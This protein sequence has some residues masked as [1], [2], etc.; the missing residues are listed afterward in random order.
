MGQSYSVFLLFNAIIDL[1]TATASA[2]GTVRV[3]QDHHGSMIFLFL[4]PCSF[5][6]QR[7]C[8]QCHALHVNL[9][10]QSTF[11][12]LLSFA[13][14]LYVVG[15]VVR[16]RPLKR[17]I[18][19]I[20]YFEQKSVS[21]AVLSRLHLTGYTASI[22]PI[23]GT[24]RATLLNT[25]IVMLSPTELTSKRHHIFI[26]RALTFQ[27]LLPLGVSVASTIWLWSIIQNQSNEFAERFL[28]IACSFFSLASPV[29]NLVMLPPYRA[30]ILCSK[31]TIRLRQTTF[32]SVQPG[33]ERNWQGRDAQLW[34]SSYRILLVHLT[35]SLADSAS[36]WTAINE[37][38][39]GEV[40]TLAPHQSTNNSLSTTMSSALCFA[41]LVAIAFGAPVLTDRQQKIRLIW[42]DDVNVTRAETILAEEAQKLGMTMDDY[43]NSCAADAESFDFT[44]QEEADIKQEMEA[45][46]KKVDNINVKT[47]DELFNILKQHAPKT[48]DAL[49]KRKAIFEKYFAK[50]DATAQQFVRNFGNALLES[51]NG[52]S[53]AEKESKNP[54]DLIEMLG[55]NIKKVKTEYDALPQS[56]KDSLERVFCIRS[57]LRIVD[58]YGLLKIV[59]AV[60]EAFTTM[61]VIIFFLV[62]L[63]AG[64]S[65]AADASHQPVPP[66]GNPSQQPIPPSGGPSQQPVPPPGASNQ[67]VPPP[68][69]TQQSK[70]KKVVSS[71]HNLIDGI[72]KP[73]YCAIQD[74]I[75]ALKAWENRNKSEQNSS[76][77]FSSS[78]L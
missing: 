31:N 72:P 46:V 67:P 25:F 3:V 56:S 50:L 34:L 20:N 1:C 24:P 37:V 70:S 29:I 36:L 17:P 32:I 22:F 60:V 4:G 68:G 6:N 45:A 78:Q 62:L 40:L 14:R 54:F 33:R 63:L 44:K 64:S 5:F 53:N 11:F 39:S 43:F 18:S 13:F 69:A 49:M 57:T 66:P 10:Q 48:Y 55:K 59:Y 75:Y 47:W 73:I 28:M 74:L 21:E 15:K 35:Y 77:W 71:F 2:M 41:V 12:L 38:V 26:A 58:E 30:A 52:L 51:I 9:V 42:G 7:L 8:R 61:F 76:L 27:M 23:Y 65:F 19:A 16:L